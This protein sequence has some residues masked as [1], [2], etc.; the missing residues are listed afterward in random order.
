LGR[1]ESCKIKELVTAPVPEP[2]F[3]PPYKQRIADV[4][5][6]TSGA[7]LR[8]QMF[9]S[10]RKNPFYN[11]AIISFRFLFSTDWKF[12]RKISENVKKCLLAENIL[13]R[14]EIFLCRSSFNIFFCF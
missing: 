8:K 14:R 1:T 10:F 11:T 13:N 12:V 9:F 6:G 4:C 2:D 3:S 7:F 5:K